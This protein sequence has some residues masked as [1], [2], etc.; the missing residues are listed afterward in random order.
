MSSLKKISKYF[1]ILSALLFV[2]IVGIYNLIVFKP[3]FAIKFID[4][5]FLP[6][7]SIQ[8]ESIDSNNNLLSPN[9]IFEKINI[10]D[11]KKNNIISLPSLRIGINLFHS[12]ASNRL[13]LSILE[14]DSFELKG[15]Q[16][17]TEFKPFFF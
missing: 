10:V 16:S 3:S 11:N 17:D 1:L 7:Y 13:V 14:V 8:I 2:L 15:S 5:V 4:K 6:E 9:F 12:L